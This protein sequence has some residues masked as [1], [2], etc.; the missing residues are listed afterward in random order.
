MW[1]L[2]HILH[3]CLNCEK[4]LGTRQVQNVARCIE[5]VWKFE[6]ILYPEIFSYY[7]LNFVVQYEKI[8]I[9]A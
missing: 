2:W 5:N 7:F 3:N 6:I 9:Y 4:K 1:P 8:N